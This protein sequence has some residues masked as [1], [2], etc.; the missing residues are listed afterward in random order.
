MFHWSPTMA[1]RHNI[2]PGEV[3]NLIH[4]F[5]YLRSREFVDQ[6][7]V[8]MGGFCV[9]ASFALVAA[10]DPRIRD[11]VVFVN[12]FGPYFDA[13]DLLVQIASRSS[14]YGDEREPWEPDKSTMQVLGNELIET[15]EDPLAKET[16]YKHYLLG[17]SEEPGQPGPSAIRRT[18]RPPY[19]GWRDIF[20]FRGLV[21][22]PAGGSSG[23]TCRLS[24]PVLT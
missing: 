5:L 16:L 21:P 23:R 7:R 15:V 10:S 17:P 11:D 22:L 13:R 2:D 12:A 1:L 3:D 6:E 19:P 18:D 8:G 9:G 14:F 24:L 20:G 4:A